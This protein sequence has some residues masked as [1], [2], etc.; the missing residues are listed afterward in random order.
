MTLDLANTDKLNIFRQELTR[1]KINLLPPDINKSESVFSVEFETTE[2]GNKTPAIRYALAAI[3]N[4]GQ[5]AINPIIAERK[6]NGIFKDLNDFVNRLRN[7]ILSKRQFESLIRAGCFDSLIKNRRK[8][9]VSVETLIK[10]ASLAEHEKNS[11]QIA[12]FQSEK[13]TNFRIPL[14][15]VN[16]WRPMQRLKEEFD[17]IGF[18]LS[19]H[20]LTIYSNL[21]KKLKVKDSFEVMQNPVNE[22]IKLAGTILSKKERT[23]AKGNRY[24]FI[25]LSDKSGTFEVTAFSETLERASDLLTDGSSI[26]IDA[27]VKY[28]KDKANVKFLAQSISSLD[29]DFSNTISILKIYIDKETPLEPLREILHQE[30]IGNGW[31]EIIPKQ[32]EYQK[33]TLRLK[34][35]YKISPDVSRAIRALPGVIDVKEI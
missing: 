10:H 27:A 1:L 18:Y 8:I 26:L 11:N 12:L 30:K 31:V 24:A 6:I 4:V 13:E 29:N 7:N 14:H 35:K 5:T 2:S 19:A 16:D 9:F 32:L 23:S 28:E 21:L 20:P 34:Q 3:K 33:L 15:E 17:A 25:Q 22:N